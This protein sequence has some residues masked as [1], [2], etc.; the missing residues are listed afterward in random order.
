[1]AIDTPHCDKIH[2]P[3]LSC[4]FLDG[5]GSFTRIIVSMIQF[6]FLLKFYGREK[7]QNVMFSVIEAQ[8]LGSGFCEFT[9]HKE[10]TKIPI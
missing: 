10:V 3:Y 5:H 4:H 9:C 8:S 7:T 1:M 6:Q 2:V